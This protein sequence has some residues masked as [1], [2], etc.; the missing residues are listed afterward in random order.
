MDTQVQEWYG[1]KGLDRRRALNVVRV[2]KGLANSRELETP[3]GIK[4]DQLGQRVQLGD[5]FTGTVW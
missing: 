1:S 3:K 2:L 4:A 5:A